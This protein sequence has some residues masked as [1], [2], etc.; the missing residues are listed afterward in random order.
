M[1]GAPGETPETIA[2]TLKVLD[3]YAI[4]L[5]VWVTLGVYLW[6]DYQDIVA[7]ARQAGTLRDDKTLFSG[8]VYVS[9]DLPKAYLEELLLT[10]RATQGYQVQFNKPSEQWMLS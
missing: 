5:G 10:L 1:L 3:D 8:A 9:P 7:E 6:T 2:E 4:P